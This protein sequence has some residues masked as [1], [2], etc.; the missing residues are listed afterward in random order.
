MIIRGVV[1]NIVFQNKENGYTV[2][3]ID[4]NG[5]LI[6][7]VGK[8]PQLREGQ[9]IEATGDFV[10]SQKW[11][12]Q[13]SVSHFETKEPSSIEGIKKYL[14]SGL[15]KGVGPVTAEAIVQKFGEKTLDI[16]EF[17]PQRLAEVRGISEGK[18]VEIGKTLFELKKMQDTVIFLS[19][20]DISTYLSVKIY[21]TYQEKTKKS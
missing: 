4:S 9:Q 6:T 18:A 14:S 10:R 12:E 11:G 2:A 5:E 1:D 3:D 16:I 19:Q 21:E 17:N 20:Y 7:I 13:F 15:V 8:M